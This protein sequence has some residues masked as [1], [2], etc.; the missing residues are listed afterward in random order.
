MCGPKF[1]TPS[2]TS[3]RLVMKLP[4]SRR[5]AG[6]SS[7]ARSVE[8]TLLSLRKDMPARS[9]GRLAPRLRNI[10]EILLVPIKP[11]RTSSSMRAGNP[12]RRLR[13]RRR[14]KS[15]PTRRSRHNTICARRMTSKETQRGGCAPSAASFEPHRVGQGFCASPASPRPS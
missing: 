2:R 12:E 1:R 14:W 5:T 7:H 6:S 11:S 8:H 10:C 9:Y 3:N 4:V 13:K 15:S